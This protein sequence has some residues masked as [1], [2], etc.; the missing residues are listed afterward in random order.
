MT[1]L[2]ELSL[3]GLIVA[4]LVLALL[5]AAAAGAGVVVVSVGLT[6]M[7]H[8]RRRE[9]EGAAGP[10]RAPPADATDPHTN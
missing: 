1:R 6:A 3:A 10:T 8:P 7:V 9:R 4:A 2:R 5:P